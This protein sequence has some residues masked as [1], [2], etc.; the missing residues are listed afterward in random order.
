M[1]KII[2]DS[3]TVFALLQMEKGYQIAEE[4]IKDAVL[5][6]INFSEIITVL[7]RNNFGQEKI[8]T[9]IY[10]FYYFSAITPS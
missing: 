6:S 7:A 2:F 8:C 9:K 3:S 10:Y 1:A 4:R 5:S